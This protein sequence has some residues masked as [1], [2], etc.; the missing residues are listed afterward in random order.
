MK[1]TTLPKIALVKRGGLAKVSISVAAAC[2]GLAACGRR[3]V[4]SRRPFGKLLGVRPDP[5]VFVEGSLGSLLPGCL[6]CKTHTG[7]R[8]TW[9][10]S[11]TS[12]CGF[13]GP[14]GSLL[15]TIGC[16]EAVSGDLSWSLEVPAGLS[17]GPLGSL[18]VPLWV[19]RVSRRWPLPACG[20]PCRPLGPLCWPLA[21]RVL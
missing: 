20:W 1:N 16:P 14:L 11:P 18:L 13:V 4:V 19:S 2:V 8:R 17:V 10:V 7:I 6:C 5:R 15:G 9:F 12:R 3:L 21:C